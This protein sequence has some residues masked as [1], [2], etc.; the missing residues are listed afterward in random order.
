MKY[1]RGTALWVSIALLALALAQVVRATTYYTYDNLGR[2]TQVIESDG[3]TT[4]YSYDANGNVTSINRIAGTTVLSIGSVSSSTGAAGSSVTI[5]GSGFSSIPGQDVVTFNGVAATVTYASGNRLVVIVPAGAGTGDISITTQA[6]SVTSASTFTVVPVSVT[7]FS[8]SSAVAGT[9]LTINGGGF[10][11]TPANNTVLINGIPAAV[12]SATV[13]QL[14]VTVPSGA[15]PGHI[16]VNAPL[17]SAVSAGDFF[18]PASG[19]TMSQISGY[20]ALVSG[21]AHVFPINPPSTAAVVLFDGTVGQHINVVSTELGNYGD[22]TVFAPDGSVFT[23]NAGLYNNTSTMLPAL[24]QTGTYA[25][26]YLPAATPTAA[27]IG[28]ET[29]VLGDIPTDGTPTMTSLAPGQSAT[30]T[31]NGTAGQTYTLTMMPLNG[32]DVV[33]PTVYNPDGSKLLAC[34]YFNAPYNDTNFC[35]FTVATTGAYTL[36]LLPNDVAAWSF[37]LY[38]VQDFSGTL[39]AGKPGPMVAETLVPGQQGFLNFAATANQT[40]ALYIN[41]VSVVPSTDSANVS[42]T[43]PSGF[44]PIG[45]SFG[46]NS[47]SVFTYNLPGLAAGNYLVTTAPNYNGAA[48]SLQAALYNGV[49]G[50]LTTDGVVTSVQTDLPGE[51]AYLT[52][53]GTQGQDLTLAV[54][55]LAFAPGSVNN[56][57]VIVTKP[58][59][60]PYPSGICYTS[61][62]PGCTVSLGSLPQTGTYT[63]AVEPD[64]MATMAVAL[65]IPP[66]VA[67]SLTL[68]NPTTVTLSSGQEA[69]LTF[70]ATANESV[71]L[72][73]S[74]IVTTPANNAVIFYVYNSSGTLVTQ[75]S[76]TA[77]G[78]LN[79]GNLAAGTYSVIVAP[80]SSAAGSMSVDLQPGANASL[81]LDGTSYGLGTATASQIAYLNFNATAGQSVGVAISNLQFT[82]ST[83]TSAVITLYNPDGSR[84]SQTA[85]CSA[86]AGCAVD[87]RGLSQTGN[88][89]ITIAPSSAATMLFSAAASL[90]ITDTLTDNAPY[91]LALNE[92]GQNAMLSFTAISGQPFSLQIGSLTTNPVGVPVTVQ[93]YSSNYGQVL[94]P[95][96]VTAGMTIP[97]PSMETGT[98]TVWIG[99]KTPATTNMQITLQAPNT[100]IV[101]ADGSSNN[102]TS[103]TVGQTA[104][105][106]FPVIAGQSFSV[107]LTNIATTPTVNGVNR[108]VMSPSGINVVGGGGCNVPGCTSAV[109]N[110]PETGMYTLIVSP[111]GQQAMSFTATI[112]QNLT[113]TITSGANETLNLGQL[114]QA[115][116]FEFTVAAGQRFIANVTGLSVVPA[117][118]TYFMG[119]YTLGSGYQFGT[120]MSSGGVLPIN[121]L[122][123]GSYFLWIVPQALAT[124]AMQFA[125]QQDPAPTLPTDGTSTSIVTNIAGENAY[126]TFQATAGQSISVALSNLVLSP[127]TS[128]SV[129]WSINSVST[130]QTV[131]GGSCAVGSLSGCLSGIRTIPTTGTYMITISPP[132]QQ[133]VSVAVTVLQNLV[134]TISPGTTQTLNL[135]GTGEFAEIAFTVPSGQSLSTLTLS[136]VSTSPANTPIWADIYAANGNFVSGQGTT[137]GETFSLSG[138]SAGTYYLWVGPETAAST[139]MQ[140]SLQ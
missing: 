61:S 60:T 2:V 64:G 43:G 47:G 45:H 106:M 110:A 102:I 74:S 138:L 32:P 17:G 16:S 118:V 34:P 104:Y 119:V 68:N 122:S 107:S 39:T 81:T 63:V 88:Y 94:N 83:V 46:T 38:V 21:E 100:T 40:L 105:V 135:S 71:I 25:W 126:P 55:Q 15:T 48:I 128:S 79:L 4:Q 33:Y 129:G 30:Y 93:V 11:S 62:T 114:G 76:M 97:L 37:G 77:N 95:T 24:T 91:D 131:G 120:T 109:M 137:S 3:T 26:Y 101:A 66:D 117:G 139:T 113:G 121:G 28:V 18:I 6:S 65:A 49:T 134:S 54:S 57:T 51:N 42:V 31:F 127:A 52:F 84:M 23:S 75:T 7:S 27:T 10:D 111:Q 125:F 85:T 108:V 12:S 36:R 50:T 130:G 8:P 5:T 140:F 19:Y 20:A 59:G 14:Q 133:T 123:A 132:A 82:P 72:S 99:P 29:D 70:V 136:G 124:G 103:P 69:A 89:S 22:Y 67:G 53:N 86:G 9:V 96:T 13:T 41:G 92:V 35:N 56:A 80:N 90:N 78:T 58:D 1:N 87:Y 73:V 44:T 98:Y 112:A 116:R 115:A